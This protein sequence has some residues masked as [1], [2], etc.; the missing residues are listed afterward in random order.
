M[1]LLSVANVADLTVVR[2]GKPVVISATVANQAKISDR[3]EPY[4]I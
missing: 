3:N 2:N 1:G 4:V